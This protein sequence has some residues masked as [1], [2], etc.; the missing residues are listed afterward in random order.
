[1]QLED[2]DGTVPLMPAD[3]RLKAKARLWV[4]W[5]SGVR[6]SFVR[7]GRRL[8]LRGGWA[9][10]SQINR[11]IVPVFF[12]LLRAADRASQSQWAHWLQAHI[13]TLVRA[14]DEEVR[15]LC[16]FPPLPGMCASR[17]RV[18][19]RPRTRAAHHRR[20]SPMA[21]LAVLRTRADGGRADSGLPKQTQGP[22]FFG[23]R[24]SLVDVHLAPFAL[25][26]GRLL[27]WPVP[28]HGTRWYRWV[29]ALEAD[30]HVRATT[31]DA[32]LYGDT[33]E[34]LVTMPAHHS[35]RV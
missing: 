20:I 6:R 17:C 30:A 22:F 34:A 8:T 7:R 32:R 33:V 35:P 2:L 1:M 24:L 5:V 27:G 29:E 15:C 19:A 23:R 14:A 31:S 25:R 12:G 16:A 3:A 26:L 9:C 10:A 21:R 13:T 18:A 4:D 11:R 28:T